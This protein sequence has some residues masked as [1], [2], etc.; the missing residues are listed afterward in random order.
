MG[1]MI[2]FVVM[3]DPMNRIFTRLDAMR[4]LG[5]FVL[6]SLFC[7]FPL[8]A[9]ELVLFE[10]GKTEATMRG[11][12]GGIEGREYIFTTRPNDR[13]PSVVIPGQWS[14][15]G[16]GSLRLDI[17][18][19]TDENVRLLCRFDSPG[20]DHGKGLRTYCPNIELAAGKRQT[21]SMAIP[22]LLPKQLEGTM[23]GM[24]GYPG[25]VKG[26]TDGTI[27]GENDFNP[28]DV[29]KITLFLASP[30]IQYKI[31]IHSIKAVHET[32]YKI[33]SRNDALELGPEEFFPMI[34]RFGQY[35]HATWPGKIESQADFQKFDEWERKQL[36]A[37]PG[38][39][40]RNRYGGWTKGPQLEATGRFRVE[41]AGGVWWLVDPEGRLFWSH[42][43]CCVHTGVTSTKITGRERYFTEFP[44][45]F[46][47]SNWK[48]GD[49]NKTYNFTESNLFLKY[50]K[51]WKARCVDRAHE[52]LKS[53]GMNTIANWSHPDFYRIQKTPFVVCFDVNSPVLDE[54]KGFFRTLPDPFHSKFRE[55]VVGNL[56]RLEE[57]LK[58][59]MCIGVFVDNEFNWGGDDVFL[60][61]GVLK[62]K[63]EQPAKQAVVEQLKQKY[64]TIEKL[65]ESWKTSH[66]NWSALLES[67][68][69]PDRKQA[70]NDLKELYALIAERYFSV[71]REEL[72]RVSPESLYLG[73][74]FAYENDAA[75]RAAAKYCDVVSY[76]RYVVDNDR[77][78]LPNG[79]D[80][81][82]IIGEF[83]FGALDRGPFH[84]G[85]QR[86][87]DQADRAVRYENYI[88][89]AVKNPQIVGAHWFQY[90]DQA[91]T[92]R[93]QDGE[94]Y[95]IGLLDIGD[96]PYPETI[97]AVRKVGYRLYDIRFNNK[98]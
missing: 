18:N 65:N 41:K 3:N 30:K 58:M 52:R 23:T 81:P 33:S 34:D 37:Y 60:A 39:E 31:G 46:C 7:I 50:G 22:Q 79:I 17:E 70:A 2:K 48:D 62:S 66:A 21:H 89:S 6:V 74:R 10:P 78:R 87:D 92:G 16:F 91:V 88:L 38:P 8:F 90:G 67:R 27:I 72:H 44:N 68:Q 75:A 55:S 98:H 73:C 63:A 86:A 24:K 56:K 95:Q 45:D 35:N 93:D 97:K 77:F 85:L 49:Q 57:R 25:G 14:L 29:I 64:E 51:D 20:A 71:I 32:P 76:N 15:R 54:C 80:K 4:T 11:V 40:D 12:D 5:F 13:W 96:T 84:T 28:D 53:W 59:P 69:P 26:K 19:H 47:K 61:D 83:H 9:Q 82:M 43:P 94:N 1:R 36:A 42:G